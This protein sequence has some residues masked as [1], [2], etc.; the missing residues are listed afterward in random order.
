M[1]V[2]GAAEQKGE[3]MPT[4]GDHEVG[5][6]DNNLTRDGSV[7]SENLDVDHGESVP[8][9][10]RILDNIVAELDDLDM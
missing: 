5:G 1:V 2:E 9:R 7:A 4:E 8:M 10:V 6:G 3:S